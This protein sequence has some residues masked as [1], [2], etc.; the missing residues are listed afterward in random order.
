[1]VD[2]PLGVGKGVKKKRKK[3]KGGRPWF[4]GGGIV[5]KG[6]EVKRAGALICNSNE[7]C[8]Q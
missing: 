4:R 8:L 1:M 7:A 6:V 3:K 2:A 5:P